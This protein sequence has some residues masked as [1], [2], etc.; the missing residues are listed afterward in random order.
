VS[1][2]RFP[3]LVDGRLCAPGEARVSTDDPGFQLGLAVFETLLYADG[4][5]QFQDQHLA[6]LAH[7]AAA[8]AIAPA[9]ERDAR[10]A[11]EAYLPA[12]D[13][14]LAAMGLREAALR[15][16]LT[17]GAPGRGPS[18]VVGAR[19]V[20]RPPPGGVAVTWE[21]RAK[22]SGD[23]L[24]G[25]K[26]TSRLRNVLAL[27]AA[28]A[29]G[30]WDA[31]LGNE[32]GEVC[33]ATAANVFAVLDGAIVTPDVERG[34]LAGVTRD[35][36]LHALAKGPREVR[37]GALPLADLARASEV[38]LTNTTG[39]VLPVREVLGVAGGFAGAAGPVAAELLEIVLAA[40]RR[41]REGR[42]ARR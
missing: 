37:V 19:Q 28:R 10:R 27:E 39:R 23:P 32:L 9:P 31:L 21:P 16:T 22:L 13:Q 25:V 8:L 11:I 15:V 24:E 4:C 30:A 6:R 2:E 26:S 7:G 36:L 29:R 14:A 20:V 41:D 3:T 34:C 40:E 12:L 33:E 5:A 17:R 1:S 35:T 38:L 42:R 18:L